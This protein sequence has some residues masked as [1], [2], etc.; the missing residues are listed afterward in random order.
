MYRSSSVVYAKKA[1]D[2]ARGNG[3]SLGVKEGDSLQTALEKMLDLEENVLPVIDSQG[4]I[5]GDLRLS[6]I[7]LKVVEE[8][9]Q[10]S[11]ED[12]QE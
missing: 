11:L 5:I 12:T 9:K 4:K 3:H 10:L 1:K 7:L 2:F 6:E 8:G